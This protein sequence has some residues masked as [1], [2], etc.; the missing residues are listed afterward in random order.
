MLKLH[1]TDD[2]WNRAATILNEAKGRRITSSEELEFLSLKI[3]NS[4]VGTSKLLHFVNPEKHPIWDSR[5]YR[6]LASERPDGSEMRAIGNYIRFL[7]I[8]DE[9]M[10]WREFPEAAR[11]FQERLGQQCTPIRVVE[12]TMWENGAP[13]K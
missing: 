3:N 12:L 10:A 7:A 8:C 4:L 13:S 5:V 11:M 6:Y 9:V 2:D 1:G